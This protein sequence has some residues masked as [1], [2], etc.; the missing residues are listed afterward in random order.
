MTKGRLIRGVFT[1][2]GDV[3]AR[4]IAHS[5]AGLLGK[6][7]GRYQAPIERPVRLYLG[8]PAS[9]ARGHQASD[10]GTGRGSGP[11]SANGWRWRPSFNSVRLTILIDSVRAVLTSQ[12]R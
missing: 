7:D 6:H 12:K 4:N 9:H 10:L 2:L 5:M 11:M 8:F 3:Y 1:G